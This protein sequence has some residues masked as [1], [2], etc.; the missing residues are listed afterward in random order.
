FF[1]RVVILTSPTLLS[2]Q[3]PT[4]DTA[5]AAQIEERIKAELPFVGPKR[6]PLAMVLLSLRHRAERP[7]DIAFNNDPPRIF[8]S[9]RPAS[10][11]VFDGEPLLTPIARTS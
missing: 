8:V 4:L 6:V 7:P 10:L 9:T 5:R 3:F 2:S 11:V 1:D